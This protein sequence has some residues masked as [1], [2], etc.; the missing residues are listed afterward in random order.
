MA[1]NDIASL[2]TERFGFSKDSSL[3]SEDS[4]YEIIRLNR[5]EFRLTA[6]IF[7]LLKHIGCKPEPTFEKTAWMYSFTVA[8][9]KCFVS[10]EKF[11]PKLY[12]PSNLTEKRK[13]SIQGMLIVG[14]QHYTNLLQSQIDRDLVGLNDFGIINQ[15]SFL[16]RG[17]ELFRA[18]TEESY[19]LEKHKGERH[20]SQNSSSFSIAFTQEPWWYS[21]GATVAY[22]SYLEHLYSGLYA[23]SGKRHTVL[24]LQYFMNLSWRKKHERL[25]KEAGAFDANQ[26]K[27][28]LDIFQQQRN[29]F[30]HG[31]GGYRAS[32]IFRFIPNV[33][34]VPSSLDQEIVQPTFMFSDEHQE[35]FQANCREFDLFDKAL[36]QGSLSHGIEWA[37]SGLNFRFD[38][39]F[40][41]EL[42]SALAKGEFSDFLDLQGYLFDKAANFE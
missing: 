7:G 23:F 8:G 16:R 38:T 19:A 22:F 36:A 32:S 42:D 40:M 29:L 35:V 3:G 2:L 25:L 33:G 26:Y 21:F 18:K 24:E 14:L 11:G 5:P 13:G 12:V 9:F 39:Q 28:L 20:T 17:Y 27:R 6:L 30:S 10:S 4:R 1:T 15:T 37:K 34:F 41:D 31:L